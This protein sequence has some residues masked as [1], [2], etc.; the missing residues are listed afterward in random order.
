[1]KFLK[2]IARDTSYR[3]CKCVINVE[4]HFWN[5]INSSMYSEFYTRFGIVAVFSM[6]SVIDFFNFADQN[7]KVNLK[8]CSE[9]VYHNTDYYSV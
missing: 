4:C 1:M 7:V 8:K 9:C 6:I 5:V 2:S 3:K